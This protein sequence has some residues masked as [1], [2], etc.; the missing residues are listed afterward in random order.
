MNTA[1]PVEFGH[2]AM[3]SDGFPTTRPA[4]SFSMNPRELDRF[5]RV[6]SGFSSSTAMII[7]GGRP[8]F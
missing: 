1:L 8:V 4:I 7:S 6:S 3:T 5:N 2:A